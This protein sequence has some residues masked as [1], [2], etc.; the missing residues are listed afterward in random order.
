[1]THYDQIREEAIAVTEERSSELEAGN[2]PATAEM[3]PLHYAVRDAAGDL[4][5]RTPDLAALYRESFPDYQ[6]D[7]N[8][9]LE[10]VRN[11][12]QQRQVTDE[13]R[14]TERLV[15][16]HGF[17][18]KPP[19]AWKRQIRPNTFSFATHKGMSS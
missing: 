2:E 19:N 10:D 5:A 8:S 14:F 13:L 15:H 9:T 12:V 3:P 17:P 7:G 11:T 18:G 16:G 1:M 6:L 4:A